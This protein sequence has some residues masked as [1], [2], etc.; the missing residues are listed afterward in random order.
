[1]KTLKSRI[2]VATLGLALAAWGAL[3]LAQPPTAAGKVGEA[4]DSTGRAIKRGVR[5]AGASVREGFARTRTTV[6]NMEVVSRVYSRIHWDKTLTTATIDLEVQAG[7]VTI[8][9]GVVPDAAAKTK[10][11]ELAADTVGVTRVVDELAI[12]PAARV[13]PASPATGT[14]P[15]R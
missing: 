12:A 15:R 5:G 3:G 11:V 4:L 2:G 1:M 10:A 7:G 6:Q 8:L 9:R 14:E 13:I